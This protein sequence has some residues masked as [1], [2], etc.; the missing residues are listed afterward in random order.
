[1]CDMEKRFSALR[2]ALRLTWGGLAQRLDLSRSMMDQVRKGQ[3][4]LSFP[5]LARLE[6]AER[7]AGLAPPTALRLD[8][9][10][11]SSNAS[12][13]GSISDDGAELREIATTLRGLLQRV[14]RL[15]KRLNK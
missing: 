14:E 8:P 1:M 7:E 2:V 15:E 12:E 9:S 11:R 6:E 5:A 10:A 13:N 4:N 3:R